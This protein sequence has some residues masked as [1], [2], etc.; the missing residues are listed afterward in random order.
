LTGAGLVVR[1]QIADVR[2][3]ERR[4]CE[5][6]QAIIDFVVN[7]NDTNISAFKARPEGCILIGATRGKAQKGIIRRG[8]GSVIAESSIAIQKHIKPGS[9]EKS[10]SIT[11]RLSREDCNFLQCEDSWNAASTDVMPT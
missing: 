5:Y 7:G 6:G 4:S 8:I 3:I 2:N 10:L 1:S 9:H 11:E